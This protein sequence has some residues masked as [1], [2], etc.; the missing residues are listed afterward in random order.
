[1]TEIYQTTK[2]F[3]PTTPARLTFVERESVQDRLVYSLNTP[4]KQIVVYGHSGVGKTTLLVNKLHQIYETHITT[5][6]MNGMSF[7]EI[8]LDAFGQ[9]E[10][11]YISESSEKKQCV[12]STHLSN[13]FLNI[14][15]QLT[16]SRTHE[17]SRKLSPVLPPQLTPQNLGKFLGEVNGCWVLEDFH[18]VDDVEKQK[19]SQI[20]KVFM[21]LSD[22][23]ENLKIIAIGAVNTARQVIAYDEEMKNRVSEIPVLLMTDDEIRK[24]IISGEDR[25]KVLFPEALKTQIIKHSIGMA[26]ICHSLCLS[27]CINAGITQTVTENEYSFTQR[28]WKKALEMLLDETSDTIKS[29][30]EKAL[31]KKRKNKFHHSQIIINALCDFKET[32]AGRIDLLSKIKRMHTDYPNNGIKTK[33]D[34]LCLVENGEIL[35]FDSNSGAYSFRNPNYLAY[36]QAL[37]KGSATNISEDNF[38]LK[39]SDLFSKFLGD[40]NI[41][42]EIIEEKL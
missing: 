36:A 34:S 30:F 41:Q 10:R 11:V 31:K 29:A 27:M 39:L 33:L 17:H 21:D 5:R 26:S 28:D 12:I 38:A 16:T 42:I 40:K 19:I 4:G 3:T 35:R 20:M 9:L 15:S 14:K 25:L 6:C 8:L 7:N 18:K 1:M 32:G 37:Q 23:Y 24:I 22:E 13:D 2:V